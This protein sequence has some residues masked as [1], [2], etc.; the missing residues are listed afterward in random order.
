MLLGGYGI[1]MIETAYFDNN[2]KLARDLIVHMY[3]AD[4]LEELRERWNSWP[5][6]A[7]RKRLMAQEGHEKYQPIP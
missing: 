6:Y 4:Y 5:K 1:D 7:A 3:G 2:D